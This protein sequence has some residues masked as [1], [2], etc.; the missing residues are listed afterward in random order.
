MP[1]TTQAE[2]VHEPANQDPKDI[3]SPSGSS[4][5]R[6]E[7]TTT[8]SMQYSRWKTGAGRTA[9]KLIVPDFA[10]VSSGSGQSHGSAKVSYLYIKHD[11]LLVLQ[12]ACFSDYVKYSAGK[13]KTHPISRR[14][15]KKT[16]RPLPSQAVK[17]PILFS[18]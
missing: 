8:S 13:L 3:L 4:P 15:E 2:P 11:G 9:V 7:T 18:R 6:L 5:A 14:K 16:S 10:H 12:E 17:C 1:A